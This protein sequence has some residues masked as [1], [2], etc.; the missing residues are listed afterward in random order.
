MLKEHKSLAPLFF[1][2]FVVTKQ[3]E[4]LLG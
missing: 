4:K 1:S 3:L 2:V